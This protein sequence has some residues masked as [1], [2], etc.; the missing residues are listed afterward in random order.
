[1]LF[2]RLDVLLQLLAVGVFG[3]LGEEL[4]QLGGGFV[5]LAGG[6]EEECEA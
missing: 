2:V 3:A 6:V 5:L 4:F 1:M